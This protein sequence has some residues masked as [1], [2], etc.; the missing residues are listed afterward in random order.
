MIKI[1]AEESRAKF[2]DEFLF[3]IAFITE[4]HAS[5]IPREALLVFCPVHTFMRHG[6]GV[7]LGIAEGLER[8]HLHMVGPFGIE[9][10]RSAMA[11]DSAGRGKEPVGGI[12]A[13]QWGEGRRLGFRREMHGQI[14][15]L[16]GIEHG[17]SLH[18]RD[19][20]HLLVAFV[21]GLGAGDA[22]GINDEL[23]P[24]AF[25]HMP[26]EL[27]RLPEGEPEGSGNPARALPQRSE[28]DDGTGERSPRAAGSLQP[29]AAPRARPT[30][31]TAD[32]EARL[33]DG[34]G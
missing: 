1:G 23:A 12:D 5:E 29:D 18:E 10:A 31:G 24:L 14:F 2:S 27:E 32:G 15:A 19:F 11:D 30:S 8:R 13:L 4:P 26:A 16:L 7:T 34:V 6:G 25:L 17:V 3:R 33:H 21:V 28:Q 20:S 9:S 22:V